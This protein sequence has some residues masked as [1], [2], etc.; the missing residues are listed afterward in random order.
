MD[1]QQRAML[2]EVHLQQIAGITD[3]IQGVKDNL[4]QQQTLKHNIKQE[5]SLEVFEKIGG[6]GFGE[7]FKGSFKGVRLRIHV[8]LSFASPWKCLAGF[9]ALACGIWMHAV[10]NKLELF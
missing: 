10:P 5:A 6:G 3:M 8:E 1:A 2:Q 7:V 9:D 4:M